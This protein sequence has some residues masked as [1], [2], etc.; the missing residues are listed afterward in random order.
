ML[1]Y[2]T[3]IINIFSLVLH[4]GHSLIGKTAILHIVISGSSPG[5]SMILNYTFKAREAQLVERNTE[6]V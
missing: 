3:Q 5:V 6:D 2:V 4:R 1:L